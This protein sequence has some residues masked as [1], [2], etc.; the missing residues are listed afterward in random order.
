MQRIS[1]PYPNLSITLKTTGTNA[2]V[3]PPICT[4][5]PP[6][7]EMR[8]PAIPVC[9]HHRVIGIPYVSRPRAVHP[10]VAIAADYAMRC[11]VDHADRKVILFGCDDVLAVGAEECIVRDEK[12][13]TCRKVARARKLPHQAPLRVDD[14]EPVIPLVGNQDISG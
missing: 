2:A 8:K 5:D 14:D 9:Q 6:K 7:S 11:D 4:R 1:P 3:G 12:R 13:L 10:R